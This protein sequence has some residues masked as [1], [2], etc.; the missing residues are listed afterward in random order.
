MSQDMINLMVKLYSIEPLPDALITNLSA[1][2]KGIYLDFNITVL[3]EGLTGID[4][5]QLTVNSGNKEISVLN[6]GEIDVGYGR[7]LRVGNLKLPSRSV[8]RIEFIIDADNS[9]RELNKKNNI[10]VMVVEVN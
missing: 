9:V 10:V 6:L 5:I 1:I 4:N 2:K 7:T 3:N 8:E